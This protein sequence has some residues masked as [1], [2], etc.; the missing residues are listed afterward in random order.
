ME[1]EYISIPT[2]WLT[3]ELLNKYVGEQNVDML[4]EN[5]SLMLTY[6]AASGRFNCIDIFCKDSKREYICN[7]EEEFQSLIAEHKLMEIL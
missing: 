7:S 4:S 5:K 1:Y 3:K 2:C 6:Y